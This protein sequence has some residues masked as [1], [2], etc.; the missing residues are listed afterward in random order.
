VVFIL[1]VVLV[2]LTPRGKNYK[3]PALAINMALPSKLK[4]SITSKDEGW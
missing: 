1:A 2:N 4:Q 3:K